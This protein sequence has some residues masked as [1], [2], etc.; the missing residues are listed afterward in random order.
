MRTFR[1][2]IPGVPIHKIRHKTQ[3]RDKRG[4]VLMKVNPKTGKREPFVRSYDPQG[5]Q[6]KGLAEFVFIHLRKN[7]PKFKLFD[8]PIFVHMLFIMPIPHHW[9]KYKR[10]AI[11]GGN[12][13]VWHHKKPDMSN[14]TKFPEDALNGILWK[15]DGQVA[16]FN[17]KKFYG[18]RPRTI[19]EIAQLDNPDLENFKRLG[20]NKSTQPKEG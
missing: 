18:E 1:I 16:I 10:N 12:L 3:T 17:G 4:R 19:I 20:K 15:D 8:G 9:P 11:L 5:D 6:K 14:L 2:E 7:F 13:R